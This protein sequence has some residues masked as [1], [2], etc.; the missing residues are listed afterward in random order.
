ME[1]FPPSWIAALFVAASFCVADFFYCTCAELDIA[2]RLRGQVFASEELVFEQLAPS[3][4]LALLRQ[5][6]RLYADSGAIGKRRELVELLEFAWPAELELRQERGCG[7]NAFA[8]LN[9]L[10]DRWSQRKAT[11]LVAYLEFARHQLYDQCEQ[12]LAGTLRWHVEKELSSEDRLKV[13]LLRQ[14][15]FQLNY[16]F[17]PHRPYFF[18]PKKVIKEGVLA[19]MEQQV[20][21]RFEAQLFESQVGVYYFEEHFTRLVTKSCKSL[22]KLLDPFVDIYDIFIG[23]RLE[24]QLL[25]QFTREWLANARVCRFILTDLDFIL[26]QS[27]KLLTER[28]QLKPKS[29]G[30]F[31]ARAF[32]CFLK[33]KVQQ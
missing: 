21:G 27:Y 31:L 29:G 23:E 12:T 9:A 8:R 6:E 3:K 16:G 14:H 32:S 19:Y 22:R 26:T 18:I 33:P 15:I 20:G 28:Q 24:A 10:L 4:T 13:R 25:S 17:N 30:G 7:S 11:N 5:L 2:A 1:L